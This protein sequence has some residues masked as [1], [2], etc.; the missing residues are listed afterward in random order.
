MTR[1]HAFPA[2]VLEQ[3]L[4]VLGKTGSGKTSSAKLAI[5]QA[6]AG[7]ARVCVL[8]PIKSDWWG[9]TS[10]RDGRHAGLPFHIL[11]GPHG[12]VPLHASAGKAIA[13]VVASGALPLSIVDMADF[14][15]GGQARFFVDFAQTL[16]RK[17][18]G[19]VYLVLEEAHLFAPKERSGIGQENLAIHWAK[20][21]ATAGRSKGIRLVLVTQ[22]TQALHNALLGSCDTVIAH[23][24]TAPADQAPVVQW[25]KANTS[26]AVLEQVSSSLSSLKTGEAWICAGE[27]R[28]FERVHFPRIGTYDNTATPTGAGEAHEVTTAAVDAE[29]LRAM[30]GDAVE[31]AKADDPKELRKQIAEQKAEIARLSKASVCPTCA[32]NAGK[33]TSVPVLTDADR[34]LLKEI[35]DSLAETR[36]LAAVNTAFDVDDLHRQLQ[37]RLEQFRHDVAAELRDVADAL[38]ASLADKGFQRI[39]DRLLALNPAASAFGRRFEAAAHRSLHTSDGQ[40]PAAVRRP[41]TSQ[42][43]GER[44]P[45]PTTDSGLTRAAERK[46]LTVLAQYPD[47]RNVRQ[48]AILAGY[49]MNGGGFRNAIGRLRALGYLEGRGELL[50]ITGAGLAAL[51]SFDPLPTG[52]ALASHWLQQLERK[53][54]REVLQALIEAY[55]EAL[56]PEQIAHRTPTRYEPNGGGFRNALG[57]LRTLELITGRGELRASEELFS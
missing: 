1:F 43:G 52:R 51:G 21:L 23:R 20:T 44:R 36:R 32:A 5:E 41:E 14:E 4:A 9:L 53:A 28:L 25:L 2:A 50:K 8:D 39:L 22:R 11:G 19:V 17:M 55:P 24:L 38:N 7:G 48:V 33:S 15:P 6:V 45:R 34:A 47:G 16:L 35:A 40:P 42:G 37:S 13:E 29:Q 30:I 18:R 3:H 26:K 12:H 56:T 57:K 27:A 31:Q 49:A 10:S 46:C 54:E